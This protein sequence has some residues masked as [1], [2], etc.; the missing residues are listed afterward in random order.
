MF[1][2]S[3]FLLTLY[4]FAHTFCYY[5][6]FSH[7]YLLLFFM[8]EGG[9]G[10]TI[11]IVNLLLLIICNHLFFLF[12]FFLFFKIFILFCYV[13]LF[14]QIKCIAYWPEL[15]D[16]VHYGN[17]AVKCT[18]VEVLAHF[19][20]RTFKIHHITEVCIC[21]DLYVQQNTNRPD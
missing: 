8:C 18:S 10:F 20:I 7:Y 19:T 5:S 17:I 6:L 4:I 11:I 15:N 14:S 13:I 3:L 1:T 9:D 21:V 16:S 2:C 12:F